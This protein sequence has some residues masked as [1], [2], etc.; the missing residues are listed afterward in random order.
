[1]NTN[2][3]QSGDLQSGSDHHP[4]RPRFAGSLAT[5][6]RSTARQLNSSTVGLGPTELQS[7]L[8]TEKPKVQA[9]EAGGAGQ[10]GTGT[11]GKSL[12]EMRRGRGGASMNVSEERVSSGLER[13][14]AYGV[15]V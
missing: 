14:A 2:W 6:D 4:G 3:V 8:G 7:R 15:V 11:R 13:L 10:R 5:L 9:Q 12:A 1:M